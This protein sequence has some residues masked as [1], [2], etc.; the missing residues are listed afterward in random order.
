MSEKKWKLT[1]DRKSWQRWPYRCRPVKGDKWHAIYQPWV[2]KAQGFLTV[3]YIGTGA[4]AKE[5]MTLCDRHEQEKESQRRPS[6][7][8]SDEASGGVLRALDA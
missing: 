8:A 4:T 3:Q 1:G 2:E 5:A 6:F 7:P